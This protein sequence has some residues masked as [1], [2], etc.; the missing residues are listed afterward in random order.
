MEL[1]PIYS[2]EFNKVLNEKFSDKENIQN[3]TSILTDKDR[4]ENMIN[5]ILKNKN[6]IEK[7]LGFK[8]LKKVEFYIVR[9]EKFKSFSKPITIEYSI[10]PEEM[11]LY[12][13]KEVLKN[14]IEIRFLDEV[15][16]E[17]VLNSFI[18]YIIINGDFEKYDF[19]KYLK[20]LHDYSKQNYNDYS[21]E[22]SQKYDF[23]K[24]TLKKYL[25]MSYDV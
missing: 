22:N 17:E 4:F 1:I 15:F 24:K 14:S 21:F 19:V 20:S 2:Y 16:R 25:E 23:D 13:L 7:K 6:L 18:T 10:L 8:L 3:Y 11:I 9:C 12:L 5:L